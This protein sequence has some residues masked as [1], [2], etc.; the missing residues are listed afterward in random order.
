M[1]TQGVSRAEQVMQLSLLRADAAVVLVAV[2]ALVA[3]AADA[4]SEADVESH[5]AAEI[6]YEHF[7]NNGQTKKVPDLETPELVCPTVSP[8]RRRERERGSK[9]RMT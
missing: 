3:A 6:E 8:P 7:F 1:A 5:K 2:V 9:S 4:A